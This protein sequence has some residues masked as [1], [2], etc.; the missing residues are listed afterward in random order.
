[1]SYTLLGSAVKGGAVIGNDESGYDDAAARREAE[2][3]RR[4]AGDARREAE[5][6]RRDRERDERAAQKEVERARQDAEKAERARA[7]D[8]EQARR[9][10]E[11]RAQDAAKAA[12]AVRRDQERAERERVKASE[13]AQRERERAA[14]DAARE[15]GRALRDAA[16]AERAAALAQ[17]RAAREAERARAEAERAGD[18][19]PPDLAGLPRDL[20][21]LWRT[22]APGRRGPRP[23]LTVE[24]I[25]DAG[26]TLAD[27]EGI[28]AVSMA[29]LAESLGFTTMSLYRYVSS[30]DEVLALMSDRAGG[31]PPEV[32]P[33]VGDWRA[34]LE[35]LLEEQRPVIAAHPWLAHTTTVLHA[36]GPNRLAW[37]E[38]MLATLDDTPL[39]PAERLA[40]IGT[41]AAHMLDEARV[42]A[43]IADRRH[44][45][46]D[47]HAPAPDE[48]VLMLADEQTHPALVA[49]ARAGA[50]AAPAD[51]GLPFGTRLILD[52]IEA[53]IARA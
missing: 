43:A 44:A 35:L 48:L 8:A 28:G 40:A 39:P 27:A 33:A 51:E 3:A 7:K 15:A 41:L 36:L 49:A 45:L 38:A 42:A 26:I 16:K 46:A 9:D 4:E 12:D 25:A 53:M 30:K 11:R 29:R 18:G 2:D 17:Q 37:M 19:P 23:G 31:R 10:E 32:G 52:G 13:N 47:E 22:P 21:V 5:A 24:Q 20:A 50:F 1:M 14:R 6:L 34:R